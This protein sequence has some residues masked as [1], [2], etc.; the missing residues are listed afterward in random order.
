MVLQQ[1]LTPSQT[2]GLRTYEAQALPGTLPRLESFLTSAGNVQLSR[3]PAWLLVLQQGLKHTPY[4]LEA[5]E[6][7]QTRGFLALAYVHSLLFGRFLVSLPY[8]NYGGVVADNQ[9]TARLL[10][11]G[12]VQLADDLK[13]RY[14]ELRHEQAVEHPSL[15][16]RRDG[17]VHMR[18][19]LAD[20]VGKLWDRLPSKVRNQVRK[21]QKNGL[22]TVWG[23]QELVPEFYAVFSHTMRDLGTPAYSRQLFRAILQHFPENA[24]ICVVRNEGRP[25]AAALLLHGWGIT[26]VPSA[27]ALH[28]Y[29]SSCANMLMYWCLLERAVL[30]RQQV[31]DFGR[32]SLGSN[33]FRFK[34][35]WGAVPAPAGWQYHLRKGTVTDMT[36]DNPRHQRLIRTWRRLPVWLTRLIGPAIVRGIP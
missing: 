7:T 24:E 30:R 3:H 17:K 32:S 18:L 33:C 15:P 1:A 6:G 9:F 31:F 8:V 20:T 11:D 4:C 26:E 29:N 25:I 13:V 16:N 10:I 22:K 19:A 27:S 2:L 35:Q 12:A 36:V 23:G 21:G 14:L 34:K 28:H 5:M